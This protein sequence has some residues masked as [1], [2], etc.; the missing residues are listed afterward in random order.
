MGE[1]SGDGLVSI[2]GDR[3]RVGGAREVAALCGEGPACVRGGCKLDD[4]IVSIGSLVWV[5]G[6]GPLAARY[7]G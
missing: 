7:D 3:V 4:V 5:L 2:H 1:G 6:E